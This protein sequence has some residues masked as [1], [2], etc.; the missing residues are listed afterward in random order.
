[1]IITVFQTISCKWNWGRHFQF[2]TSVW[3]IDVFCADHNVKGL[4]RD[5]I[6]LRLLW[7]DV[8]M[9]DTSPSDMLPT[10]RNCSFR[11]DDW[12]IF[13]LTSK[14][15]SLRN[16]FHRRFYLYFYIKGKKVVRTWWIHHLIC[17]E[18]QNWKC[19]HFIHNLGNARGVFSSYTKCPS[20]CL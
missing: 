11:V 9:A 7:L 20:V 2:S 18:L 5:L 10:R 4:P 6:R 14:H 15:I 1:M 3:Y 12:F 16:G 17:E 8:K 19:I 13:C